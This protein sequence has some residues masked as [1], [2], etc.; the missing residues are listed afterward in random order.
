MNIPTKLRAAVAGPH[1][2]GRK[3]TVCHGTDG[4]ILLNAA[5]RLE[6]FAKWQEEDQR[7]LQDAY[8]C[9]IDATKAF[10]PPQDPDDVRAWF[11]NHQQTIDAVLRWKKE[12]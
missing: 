8:R 3:H 2:K 6:Q 12:R 4:S 5:D 1:E 9:I 11:D 10:T 7:K